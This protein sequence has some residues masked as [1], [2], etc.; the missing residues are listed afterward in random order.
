MNA[1]RVPRPAI[2]EV[3][4]AESHFRAFE[5]IKE[6]LI[7]QLIT[8]DSYFAEDFKEARAILEKIAAGS[9]E[10]IADVKNMKKSMD[11]H[12]YP[13][14]KILF[15]SP[16][17]P[18][19]VTIIPRG[20]DIIEKALYSAGLELE[21]EAIS[22]ETMI[23]FGEARLSIKT[24]ARLAWEAILQK[25]YKVPRQ[26]GDSSWQRRVD[27]RGG[28]VFEMLM[29][30]FP[31]VIIKETETATEI[32]KDIVE[33][34]LKGVASEVEVS[35]RVNSVVNAV[36]RRMS[37]VG[38]PQVE[39]VV[40][41]GTEKQIWTLEDGPIG[42]GLWLV[43]LHRMRTLDGKEVA[44]HLRV[45][46]SISATAIN[47]WPVAIGESKFISRTRFL[48]PQVIE[49][50]ERIGAGLSAGNLPRN[51]PVKVLWGRKVV[52]IA[53][54]EEPLPEG[55]RLGLEGRI[56]KMINSPNTEILF[57]P[58]TKAEEAKAARKVIEIAVDEAISLNEKQKKIQR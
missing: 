35:D 33:A 40:V 49:T 5:E 4:V 37:A 19:E 22:G 20:L 39:R 24:L 44:D 43:A 9:E 34:K 1:R 6:K 53:Q 47:V 14:G 7:A 13:L 52:A 17:D 57:L 31:E 45:I 11:L 21:K 25:K 23:K 3:I 38:S 51:L 15:T 55:Q 58:L 12:T 42:E 56:R 46:Y 50:F 54:S 26:R 36:K 10:F 16:L 30:Y 32:A 48:L 2:K 41:D 8:N 28:V 27:Q 18:N 29:P